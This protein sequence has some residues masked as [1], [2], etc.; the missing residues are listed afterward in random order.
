MGIRRICRDNF[1]RSWLLNK[2]LIQNVITY[3]I[4]IWEENKV[5]EK[6]IM[7]YI[8]WMFK[9]DFC[10]PRYIIKRERENQEYVHKIKID[11]GIRVM[12]Y[13]WTCRLK[14]TN[15]I[16]KACSEEKDEMIQEKTEVCENEQTQ[17]NIK[18]KAPP[19][20]NCYY[21]CFPVL[22]NTNRH[23]QLL[24]IVTFLTYIIPFFMFQKAVIINDNKHL[25]L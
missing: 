12:R 18:I 17:Y 2:Y 22:G 20:A 21:G 23:E 9:I 11:R 8:R 15:S 16:I 24:N 13:K 6:I 5:L 3:D 14:T 19:S 1:Y 4:E 25:F 10:I 7:D